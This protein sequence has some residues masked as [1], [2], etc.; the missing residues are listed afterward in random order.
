MGLTYSA[1][2]KLDLAE[3]CVPAAA[4]RCRAALPR[5]ATCGLPDARW[6]NNRTRW[7]NNRT[8]LTAD[9]PLNTAQCRVQ[10]RRKGLGGRYLAD[11]IR[12]IEASQRGMPTAQPPSG[13]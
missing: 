2:G 6:A 11:A 3:E 4:C 9:R 1:L 5:A 13:S 10:P 8:L 12:L 7:A